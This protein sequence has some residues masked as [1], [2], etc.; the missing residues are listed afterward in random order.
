M[1]RRA[2]LLVFRFA[3]VLMPVGIAGCA[4][5]GRAA[6]SDTV[7]QD[8]AVS[9]E[10][11]ANDAG[12]EPAWYVLE[13]DGTLRAAL[14]AP[15]PGSPIPPRV[16][17]LTPGARA[18]VWRAVHEADWIP[19]SA[20]ATRSSGIRATDDA[21]GGSAGESAGAVRLAEV[22]VAAAGGRWSGR[23]VEVPGSPGAQRL[24][25]VIRELR[26]L[27]WLPTAE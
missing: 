19:A 2:A 23:V 26:R 4:A 14:G 11:E 25:A 15:L 5:S 13:A 6:S 1:L 20:S 18:S 10:V 21:T 24:D 3:L 16:R 9:I 22:Y 8:F 12:L 27:A 17:T 7:P